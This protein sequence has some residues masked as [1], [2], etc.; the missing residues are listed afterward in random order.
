MEAQRRQHPI[1]ETLLLT[2]RTS[3]L[4]RLLQVAG[5]VML[6]PPSISG[7][8]AP[9]DAEYDSEDH[10]ADAD[11]GAGTAGATAPAEE[12]GVYASPLYANSNALWPGRPAVIPVCWEN[13]VST[14]ATQRTW[15]QHA[16]QSQWGRYGRIN[17]T[18]WGT[19]TAGAAGIHVDENTIWQSTGDANGV[20]GYPWLNARKNGLHVSLLDA[21]PGY[22]TTEHCIRALALHEFGHA[23]GFYHEEQRKT[24][25][26]DRCGESSTYYNP[27]PVE[28]GYYDV[29]SVMSYKGQ[30]APKCTPQNSN[31]IP[32][33]KDRLSPGDIAGIQ[34]AYG[35]HIMGSTVAMGGKC[36]SGNSST[37]GSKPFLWD[38]DEAGGASGDQVWDGGSS[39]GSR[40]LV[41][42]NVCLDLPNGNTTNNT[43]LQLYQC[44]NNSNQK[45]NFDRVAIRGWGGKC[46]DLPNGN[47]ASGTKVQ[48]YDCLGEWAD[49]TICPTSGTCLA[50]SNNGNLSNANQRWTITG[51]TIKY[52]SASS[53]VCLT[54]PST[55]NGG[56]LY[57]SACGGANQTFVWYNQKL[58]LGSTSSGKCADVPGATTSQYANGIGNPVNGTIPQVYSCISGQLNQSWNVTG[59]LQFGTTTKVMD[60]EGNLESN[61]TKPIIWTRI[62]PVPFD[63]KWDVY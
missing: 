26:T 6:V 20:S 60:R 62:S 57:V 63:E 46:L 12:V 22:A 9:N 61:G 15:V 2:P 38:C 30:G 8:F 59:P 21:C 18:G 28:Y 27:A 10:G 45:W 17:F 58:Y 41:G 13:P 47:T 43:Y 39:G 3:R 7:C 50:P 4:S 31:P 44:L 35:R 24:S 25:V 23:L 49:L 34:A 33:W 53:N 11:A 48:M 36:L 40:R 51:S 37:N 56:Q 52:G 19:C 54:Y 14:T 32:T 5:L 29:D 1:T 55:A 16:V 42:R